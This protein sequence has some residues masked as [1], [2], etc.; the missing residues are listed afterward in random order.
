MEN[1]V[2]IMDRESNQVVVE[3]KNS[4]DLFQ[5]Q[6]LESAGGFDKEYF[7]VIHNDADAIPEE[8][9]LGYYPADWEPYVVPVTKT[10]TSDGCDVDEEDEEEIK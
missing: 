2:Y 8:D 9:W 6:Q 5:I 10:E 7:V 4:N 1:H 3:A